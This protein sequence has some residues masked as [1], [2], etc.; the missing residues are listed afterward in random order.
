M[1]IELANWVSVVVPIG[2]R[3]VDV[4]VGGD[5]ILPVWTR[6]GSARRVRCFGGVPRI[7]MIGI[8]DVRVASVLVC[9]TRGVVP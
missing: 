5:S 4:M 9:R 3:V 1:R 2:G 7:P 6:S 8:Y